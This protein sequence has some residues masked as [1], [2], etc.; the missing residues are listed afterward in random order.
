MSRSR[1]ALALALVV[2]AAA[3]GGCGGSS[4]GTAS[5]ETVPANQWIGELC[6]G[7]STWQANL[8]EVPDASANTDLAK[9]KA[10]MGSFLDAL[11]RN[12]QRL[13]SRIEQAGI[14]DIP[15]GDA[16]ARAF[17]SAFTGMESSFR[18]AKTTI[19]QTPSDEA[20]K[21]AAGLT[22]VGMV[23]KDS[24]EQA[25]RAFG[26]ISTRYPGLGKAAEEV[27]ACQKAAG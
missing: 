15:E 20:Q 13:V 16:A 27:P 11:V 17:R 10:E 21:F 8:R 18:Q 24:I 23:L 26:D 2:S 25:G 3:A 7:I 14:P 19:D 6:S 4:G 12:T 9:L 1:L 22:Q 5:G